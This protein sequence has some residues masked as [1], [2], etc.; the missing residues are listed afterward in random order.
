MMNTTSK[1]LLAA[2]TVSKGIYKK[3]T[4]IINGQTMNF[5][6]LTGEEHRALIKWLGGAAAG[7]KWLLIPEEVSSRLIDHQYHGD[8]YKPN[9][10]II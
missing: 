5:H 9:S 7:L 6:S 2:W 3:V 4:V 10:L 8:T 1:Q